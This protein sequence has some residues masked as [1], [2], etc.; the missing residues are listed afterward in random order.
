VASRRQRVQFPLLVVP[1]RVRGRAAAE[2]S[3]VVEALAQRRSSD[4]RRLVRWPG[5]A[6]MT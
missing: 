2:N 3:T 1:L 5:M 6:A 4:E